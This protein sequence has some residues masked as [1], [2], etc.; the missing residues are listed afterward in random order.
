ML[1]TKCPSMTSRWI[2]SAPAASTAR[3]SSP[4]LEKSDARIDGAI[5]R[6]RDSNGADMGALSVKAVREPCGTVSRNT[7]Q[8][9]R[10]CGQKRSSEAENSAATAS[11]AGVAAA[12]GP[13]E[14]FVLLGFTQW[15]GV[16]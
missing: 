13:Q 11:I 4:S 16:C 9:R 1:G 5:T 2:Q 8:A 3:T 14:T 7:R 15:H 6:G 12:S 10:Q